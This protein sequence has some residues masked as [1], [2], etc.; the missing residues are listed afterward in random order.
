[1]IGFGL[2]LIPVIQWIVDAVTAVVL[3]LVLGFS[4]PLLGALVIEAF[5][6]LE[7][8]PTWTLVV[9]V[10]AGSGAHSR[11]NDRNPPVQ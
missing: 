11:P 7:M 6:A 2:G 4:W 10:M 5:P 9:I 1:A 8:F 3:L